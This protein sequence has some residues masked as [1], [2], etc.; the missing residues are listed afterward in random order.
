MIQVV[1]THPNN[2]TISLLQGLLKQDIEMYPEAMKLVPSI[3]MLTPS[4]GAYFTVLDPRVYLRATSGTIQSIAEALGMEHSA[5]TFNATNG[6]CLLSYLHPSILN[7]LDSR[8]RKIFEEHRKR[9]IG[10]FVSWV[11]ISEPWDDPHVA[12]LQTSLWKECDSE[13]LHLFSDLTGKGFGLRR[14]HDWGFFDRLVRKEGIQRW[15][16]GCVWKV[17]MNMEKLRSHFAPTE[18]TDWLMKEVERVMDENEARG[19]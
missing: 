8:S 4:Q 18:H 16:N 14:D 2:F 6:I 15:E 10:Q 11:K 1:K 9:V 13:L 12:D 7:K 5:D 3:N 19:L 17:G